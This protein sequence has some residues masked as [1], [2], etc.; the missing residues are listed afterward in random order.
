MVLLVKKWNSCRSLTLDD[1]L[2]CCLSREG[3]GAF[4]FGTSTTWYSG[5]LYIYSIEFLL[6]INIDVYLAKQTLLISLVF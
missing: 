6:N 3:A 4:N 2:V 5:T 1:L